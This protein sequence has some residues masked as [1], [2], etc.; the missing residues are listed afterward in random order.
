M[1]TSE[2]YLRSSATLAP[3][4]ARC[5]VTPLG[6]PLGQLAASARSRVFGAEIRWRAEGRGR[7]GG[8]LLKNRSAGAGREG[9]PFYIYRRRC[10]PGASGAQ[11]WERESGFGAGQVRRKNS[12]NS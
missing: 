8:G 11:R 4:V 1:P 9:K 7:G 3:H 12:G 6:V 10:A 2:A 5:R